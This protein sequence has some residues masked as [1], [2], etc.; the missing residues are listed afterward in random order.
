MASAVKEPE[1]LTYLFFALGLGIGLGDNQRLITI[2]AL[3]AGVILIGKTQMGP[4][5]T[6]RA[7]T[8]DGEATTR[9]AWAP[10][11]PGVSPGGSSSGSA[12]A[13]GKAPAPS[14]VNTATAPYSARA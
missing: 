2:I 14:A 10:G 3:A 9:N 13:A 4:L 8:P 6:S 12:G 5:A 11:D 7:T 1:E